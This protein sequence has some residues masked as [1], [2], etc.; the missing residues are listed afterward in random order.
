MKKPKSFSRS[1]G[2]KIRFKHEALDQL[3]TLYRYIL[4][5]NPEAGERIVERVHAFFKHLGMFPSIGRLTDE[6][7]VHCF[8][9]GKTGLL[10]YY[11]FDGREITIV[12]ILHER[13]H[14]T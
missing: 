2:Y 6:A 13:Q 1:M 10:V 7:H 9:V 5:R 8:V 3:D 11:T 14:R 12:R 4:D